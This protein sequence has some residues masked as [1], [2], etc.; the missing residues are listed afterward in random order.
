MESLTLFDS[1]NTLYETYLTNETSRTESFYLTQK[2]FISRYG[3]Q[4][5]SGPESFK[6]AISKR[7]S[8]MRKQKK[9][10]HEEKAKRELQYNRRQIRRTIQTE[11]PPQ[12][13]III[14]TKCEGL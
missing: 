4:G 13:D 14:E 7:K 12:K 11:E 6:V 1:F 2:E 9:K 5:Y 10:T 8:Q 3:W